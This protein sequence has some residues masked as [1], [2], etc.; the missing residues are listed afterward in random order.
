[1]A[2]KYRHSDRGLRM[3]I[4]SRHESGEWVMWVKD[5]GIG[6]AP[7]HHQRIFLLFQRLHSR[8][9]SSGTGMGLALCKKIVERHGGKLWVESREDEGATFYFSFPA[10]LVS[11]GNNVTAEGSV[12]SEVIPVTQCA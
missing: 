2:I 12:E 7:E 1:N 11:E 9:K 6:I 5:N 3:E 10:S 4:G 8:T